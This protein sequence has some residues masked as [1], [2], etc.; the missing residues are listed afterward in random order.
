VTLALL[1]GLAAIHVSAVLHDAVPSALRSGVASGV[2]SLSWLAF[3]PVAL[4][5]G[6]LSSAHG[7]RPAGWLLVAAA[8]LAGALLVATARSAHPATEPVE[9]GAEPEPAVAPAAVAA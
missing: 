7:V 3:L 1:V 2:S 5:F 4:G 8:V 6:A 9:T